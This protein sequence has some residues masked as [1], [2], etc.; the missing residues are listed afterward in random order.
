M[1]RPF[2]RWTAAAACTIAAVATIAAAPAQAADHEQTRTLLEQYQEAAGPGAALYAGDDSGAWTIG[3]GS[4]TI[5]ANRPITAT[6]HFRIASQTKTFTAAVVLQLFDEGLVDLDAPIEQYLPGVVDNARYDGG[7]ITVRQILQQTSGI[8]RDVTGARAN[9]DG[10]FD[11]PELVRAGLAHP[12]QFA[13]GTGWGY[14]NVNYLIAGML[15]EHFTGQSVGEAIT[16]RIIEPLGLADTSFPAIGDQSVAS[17]YVP[18]YVGGR[19]GSFFFWYDN[20]F[21]YEMSSVSSAG[22]MTSTL[23]DQS[24]FQLALAGGEVVSPEALAEMRGTAAVPPESGWAGYGLGLIH[25]SLSCGGDAWGHSGDLAT[26]HSSVTMV[27]DDGR[28]A[29]M[30]TNS[31]SQ[32]AGSPT[33]YEVVDA[34]LCEEAS[35]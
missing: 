30:M 11:L 2:F 12:P 28:F 17:P 7:A 23:A 4:A 25:L 10:T 13:P 15:I 6:D 5:T 1:A 31:N 32:V 35:A 29:S 22:A 21:G 33:R 20:T 27:T 16:A 14:S 3:S 24:A 26:G 9:P 34:A 19:I 8:A 18:G